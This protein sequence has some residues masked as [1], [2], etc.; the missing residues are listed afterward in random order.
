M[1]NFKLVKTNKIQ[2]RKAYVEYKIIL[3][4]ILC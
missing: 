3:Y 4:T 2:M 1:K